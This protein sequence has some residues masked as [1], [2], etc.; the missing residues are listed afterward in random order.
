MRFYNSIAFFQVNRIANSFKLV[1][2]PGVAVY[3]SRSLVA[4]GINRALVPFPST[5]SVFK[6]QRLDRLPASL[7]F[8]QPPAKSNFSLFA[9]ITLLAVTLVQDMKTAT[10]T[11]VVLSALFSTSV[12]FGHSIS[13]DEH[14]RMSTSLQKR[15]YSGQGTYF[16]VGL[17]SYRI[18][19]T[20]AR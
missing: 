20:E 5:S 10:I 16:L 17:V 4:F 3:L 14:K 13:R 19:D 7:S 18:C 6:F 11:N 9:H 2:R 12:A 1:P 8:T 15:D